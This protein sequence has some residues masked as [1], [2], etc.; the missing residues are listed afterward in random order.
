M[1]GAEPRTI[2]TGAELSDE[3]ATEPG[4][5]ETPADNPPAVVPG[6]ESLQ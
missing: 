5:R 2:G 3:P 4:A 1:A 6:D